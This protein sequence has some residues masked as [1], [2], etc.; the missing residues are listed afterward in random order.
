MSKIIVKG[1]SNKMKIILLPVLIIGLLI[2]CGSSYAI[3]GGRG[4]DEVVKESFLNFEVKPDMDLYLEAISGELII[5]EI[6]GKE[7]SASMKA[8]C[9]H[10][11]DKCAEHFSDL[12]FT[13]TWRGNKLSIGTN[14][15]LGFKGDRS[16]QTILSIPHVNRLNVKMAAGETNISV[17]H[18]NELSVDMKAGELDIHIEQLDS[19]LDVDLLAGEVDIEIPEDS[20]G[21]IDIDAD[22]GDASIRRNGVEEEAP[23]SFLIGA[24]THKFISD[25]GA[26]VHVDV[27]IGD[28]QLNLTGK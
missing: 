13:T 4:S 17:K 25:G 19:F 2:L 6:S 16:V 23:R 18:I 22:M 10:D 11:S 14:K 26:A 15:G 21:E 24:Q 27:Q 1:F 3:A 7:A 8:S 12:E 9:H 28:I 20:V 5:K